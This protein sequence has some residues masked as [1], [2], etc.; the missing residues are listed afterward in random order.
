[1][2]GSRGPRGEKR[3]E[4]RG[5]ARSE[6]AA[7]RRGGQRWQKPKAREVLVR[8]AAA[9]LC[10]SDLHFIEG[11]YPHPLPGPSRPRGAGIVEPVGAEVTHLKP[12]DHVIGCLSAFCGDCAQC[13][14]GHGALRN[15]QEKKTPGKP[16]DRLSS[17]GGEPMH[18]FLNL[19]CFAEHML[20]HENAWS[21]STRTSRSMWRRW[22]DARSSPASALR[23]IPPIS[24]RADRRG[25]R[26]RRRRALGDQRRGDRR[27]RGSSPLTRVAVEAPTWPRV[28]GAT[29]TILRV[30]NDHPVQQVKGPHRRRR[31]LHASRRWA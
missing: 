12:G 9:G 17:K 7:D 20:V 25:D 5:P 30:G 26:L 18:Q 27:R 3:H 19:S 28:M 21:R 29:D 23:S 6:P 4:G 14:T 8:T 15:T 2:L 16:E 31:A 1:M 11:N 13:P 22:S 24:C 10:H